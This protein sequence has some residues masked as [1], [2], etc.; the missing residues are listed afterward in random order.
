[1]GRKLGAGGEDHFRPQGRRVPRAV[2]QRG[3]R[4]LSAG[5]SGQINIWDVGSGQAVFTTKLPVIIYSAAYSPNG[6]K[7]YATAND[8]KVY[9]VDVPEAA[10]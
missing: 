10:R 9:A 6:Q 3:N 1:M 2:Q 4:I 7:V 5:Y 8:G